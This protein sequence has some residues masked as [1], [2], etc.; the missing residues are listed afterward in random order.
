MDVAETSRGLR[1][2]VDRWLDVAMDFAALSLLAAP[3]PV[4]E[5]SLH[6]VPH[7]LL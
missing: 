3:Y 6:R 1:Q 7:K 4:S 2:V 5:I